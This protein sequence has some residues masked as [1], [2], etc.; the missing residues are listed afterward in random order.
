[1]DITIKKKNKWDKKRL[2]PEP[3]SA[4]LIVAA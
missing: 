4:P 1:M 2:N 3:E